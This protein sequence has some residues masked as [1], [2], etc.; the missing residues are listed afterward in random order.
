M[1]IDQKQQCLAAVG[2]YTGRLDGIDG[3]QTRKAQDDFCGLERIQLNQLEQRLLDKISRL[4]PAAWN[5]TKGLAYTVKQLCIEMYMTMPEQWAYIMA[6][7]QHE[8][9]NTYQCVEEAYYLGRKRQMAHL[10]RLRY[11]P[12]YG[13]G[14]PQL[15]WDYNYE[16]YGEL[17]G[18]NLLRQPELA[19]IPH[20]SIFIIIHGCKTGAFTRRIHPLERH[21]NPQK[22]D[23]TNARR[24]INGTD[25]ARLIAGLAQQWTAYYK[26]TLL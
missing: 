2:L 5:S 6:T 26:S 22:V 14:Y 9:N 19:L 21:I 3:V 8:T 13:R 16:Y 11:Y 12:Y 20:Y 23:F 24:V 7:I 18:I 15:T 17:L 25:K 10:Q 1:N 4:K